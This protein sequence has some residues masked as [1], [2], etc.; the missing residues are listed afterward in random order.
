MKNLLSNP[1]VDFGIICF[2][3]IGIG[4][5]ANFIP[6]LAAFANVFY[7]SC[8]AGTAVAAIFGLYF[9]IKAWLFPSKQ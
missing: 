7:I 2:V 1:I 8:I 4:T 3:F 9:G 5:L 6:A